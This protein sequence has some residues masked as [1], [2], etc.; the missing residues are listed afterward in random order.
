MVCDVSGAK[1][2]KLIGNISEMVKGL[3]HILIVKPLEAVEEIAKNVN[4]RVTLS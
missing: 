2:L 3:L 4:T 1:S